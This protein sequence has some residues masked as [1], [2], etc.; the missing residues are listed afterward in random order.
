MP[1]EY[2]QMVAS[3]AIGNISKVTAPENPAA[4]Y[5]SGN[6][7]LNY[8]SQKSYE[9]RENIADAVKEAIEIRGVDLYQN[10]VKAMSENNPKKDIYASLLHY[11]FI[12]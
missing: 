5:M 11:K 1:S 9:G 10:P 12:N 3:Q 4:S 7:Q 6:N 8:S 2:E